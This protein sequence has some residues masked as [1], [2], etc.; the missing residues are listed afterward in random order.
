MGE[1]LIDIRNNLKIAFKSVKFNIGQYSSFFA[2]L[3]LIQCFF[4]MLTISSDMNSKIT[5]EIIYKEYDYDVVFL[6][7]NYSQTVFLENDEIR[8]FASD[9]IYNVVR[10]LD[11]YNPASNTTTYDVYLDF[12][13]EDLD[14]AMREFTK[15]YVPYLREDMKAGQTLKYN[16][17]EIYKMRSY[18][19]GSLVSYISFASI[20]TLVSILLI[21]SLYRIRVNHYKFT[22]GIYMSFGADYKQL[23]KTS[24]WEMT[25]VSLLTFIPAQLF[26]ALVIYL[27]YKNDGF[28]FFYDPWALLKI[29][30]INLIIVA[31]SVCFPMFRVSR[32]LPTKL[33]S[34]EDNSNLVISPRR[35]FNF[36]NLTFPKKYELVSMWRFRKY[37][38]IM[39]VTAV[40]F[41]SI[42]VSGFYVAEF[43]SY[44][45]DYPEPEISANLIANVYDDELIED[46]QNIDGVYKVSAFDYVYA[47]DYRSH[48]LIPS[49]SAL[50]SASTV[51]VTPD[52]PQDPANKNFR[53]TNE[54]IYIL[55]DKSLVDTISS[56]L[57]GFKVKGDPTKLF[58]EPNQV[59]VTNY[60][61]NRK[62]CDFKLGDKIKLGD[63]I[64]KIRE[65]DMYIQGRN[66]LRQELMYYKM[67]YIELEVC[68]IID[69]MTTLEGAPLFIPKD[70]YRR[71]IDDEEAEIKYIEIFAS[72]DAT[73]EE[74]K[75]LFNN[76]RSY[77]SLYKGKIGLTDNHELSGDIITKSLNYYSLIIAIAFLVLAISPLI[78]FF[79]Q[80]LFVRKRE[81]EFS[82]LLWLGTIKS[83]IKMLVR[84]NGI[85]L[86]IVSSIACML[87]SLGMITLIQM[88]VTRIP[89]VFYGGTQSYF[90]SVHIPIEAFIV[91]TVISLICGFVSSVLPLGS[92]FR[93][94]SATENSREFDISDDQ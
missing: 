48:T 82:V 47:S 13:P 53:A 73:L 84:Q 18:K 6:D 89:P 21:T 69:G 38:A 22:Y 34:S 54:F 86:G 8:I 72:P 25:V 37:L 45:V 87:L 58:T 5:D 24:F 49:S 93:R 46:F 88:A 17:S 16:Y 71:I 76:V 63:Y 7:L 42:F 36:F 85:T 26:S 90:F 4:G 66:R 68:A 27:I 20:M 11:R 92:F 60:I 40:S 83:E 51:M 94:F 3:F 19:I 9:H 2:A 31:V 55:A 10:V 65:I 23:C 56:D 74:T 70:I 77:T 33:I 29:F 81:K 41:A 57:Y 78:W 67:D 43:Y 50:P 28:E 35:S 1:F 91:S 39:I 59:I 52:R 64:G 15:R 61:G 14:Q 30:I 80:T 79:S 62:V 75:E 12:V 44:T 32:S